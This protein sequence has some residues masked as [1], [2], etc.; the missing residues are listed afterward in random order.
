MPATAAPPSLRHRP[1]RRARRARRPLAGR[2]LPV[3]LLL[4]LFLGPALAGVPAPAPAEAQAPQATPTPV[5][6][7]R[8]DPAGPPARYAL[9]RSDQLFVLKTQQWQEGQG[10]DARSSTY[11]FRSDLSGLTGYPTY[12]ET[13]LTVTDPPWPA[14]PL[15]GRFTDPLHEQAQLLNQGTDCPGTGPGGCSYT[16]VLAEPQSGDGAILPW[17]TTVSGPAGG[18]PAAAAAGDLDGR[19]SAQGFPNDEAVVAYPGVGGALQVS[20]LDYNVTPGQTAE[21]TPVVTLPALGT[22]AT[23]P[24]SLGVGVGDLDNDGQNEVAVLWQG[25]GCAAAGPQCLSVPHLSILRYTND[26][27]SQSLAVLQADVPLPAALLTGSPARNMGF[28]VAV[29]DFDGQ[30]MD[31]LAFS[32]IGP[33]AGLAVLGFAP[34]DET[35]T[36]ARFGRDPGDFTGHSYCPVGGCDPVAAQAVPQLAAG[37]F[38]YDE[39][40]GHGLGRRQLA[41]V[42]LSNSIPGSGVQVAV[43]VYDVG[44]AG[45]TCVPAAGSP[46]LLQVQG[47]LTDASGAGGVPNRQLAW[48]HGNEGALFAP[49]I[50]LA[51]GGFQGLVLHPSDPSKVP[52]ALAVGLSG[53]S[54]TSGQIGSWV[55]L[56]GFSGS[57]QGQFR[58]DL[59][60]QTDID[61]IAT[62]PRLLAYDPPG[63]S[64]V[65]GAP[66][67]FSFADRYAPSYI[68]QDP[69]KHLDWFYDPQQKHGSWL[70]VDRSD[71][72]NLDVSQ[73]K[74]S[75][76]ESQT[77]T[78]SDWTIG[79]SV[80]VNVTAS[81]EVGLDKVDDAKAGVDASTEVG[82]QYDKNQSSYDTD[83]SSRTLTLKVATNDDDFLAGTAR[84][85]HVY[86]YPILGRPL[87]DT[88]GR[89][90]LGP[91]GQPQ[92]GFY[93]VTLPGGTVPF[94]P[95][96]GRNF[97]DWYQPLHSNGN[98]LSYPPIDS[99]P[100]SPT[101]GLVKLDPSALGPAVTLAGGGG[102]LP[103]P[104]LNQAYMVD[105]TGSSV[106]LEISGTTGHGNS[107]S[108]NNTL[109]ES[110]DV[111][112]GLSGKASF[113]VGEVSG[114]ADVD[115]KLNNS[116][117]WSA[118]STSSTTTTS[119]NAFTLNQSGAAQGDWAYGAATAY[120]TDPAGVYRAAHAVNLLA[121]SEATSEWKQYYGGRPDP[122]LNLPNRMVM[123]YSQVD[124][125][126]DIP[127]WN[128]SDSRQQ[129]R[130]FFALHPDAAHGG[131]AGPLT[132]GAPFPN[133]TDGDT[134]QLQVRVHN[135][136]LNIAATNVPVEFW[137]VARDAYDENNER[138]PVKLGTV[139]IP[140][141]PALGW[142]PAN[143]LWDTKGMAPTGAQLYR[144]FVIVAAND[145]SKGAADP[146]NNV[147]HAWADRYGDPATV[148]GTRSGDR[149]TDP[150]TG[151]YETL[152]AG[153]NKQGYGE[154][155]IYPNP[156]PNPAPAALTAAAGAPAGAPAKPATPLRFGSGGLRVTS[157]GTRA[158]APAAAAGAGA[159]AAAPAPAPAGPTTDRPQ[160]VRLHLGATGTALGNSFCHDD[161]NSATLMLYEGAPEQGGQLV[162]VER[163]TGLAGSGPAGRWVT[164]PWTPRGTGRTQLVA[165]LYGAAP[166]AR[167]APA[168]ATL[169]VD[170]A[171]PAAPPATLGRLLEVLEV[172]WLP[173][174]LR[175]ALAA[176]VR[177]A[178][179]AAL[180][181]DQP[182]ARAAL[183]A[184]RQQVEAARGRTVSGYTVSRL[185]P[186]VDDLLAQ[187]AIAG[188]CLPGSAVP[189]GAAGT[190]AGASPAAGPPGPA[191]ATASPSATATPA[192]TPAPA[193]AAGAGGA[194]PSAGTLPPC[195]PG[196][197]TAS[198]TPTPTAAATGTPP[199][200]TASPTPTA[201]PAGP[202]PTATPTP[203]PGASGTLGTPAPAG[204]TGTPART[205][206]AGGSPTPT[207]TPTAPAATPTA[208]LTPP[209]ATPATATPVPPTAT[210]AAAT[211]TA[212]PPRA[213][214]GQHLGAQPAHVQAA[215]LAT[216][217]PAAPAQWV[218][219]HEAELARPAP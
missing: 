106:T 176:R 100:Q 113:G 75:A 210:P 58:T 77:T 49:T 1:A 73:N 124:K 193:G 35:F 160:E 219:E 109:S 13:G 74:T 112:A 126:N 24:G 104:L 127:T 25:P 123:T 92:Y 85:W 48:L 57:Q 47:L 185:N 33:D 96:G 121:S 217:G 5:G 52:W 18:S 39:A 110:A 46:C 8:S 97:G 120:Y 71:S 94:G 182:G 79:G 40:S 84:S 218:A 116:N 154:V 215:F 3:A 186:L 134:V 198:P 34:L 99:D 62:S 188:L 161:N 202:S 167:T 169:A 140:A 203:T 147:V 61:Q 90:V 60:L 55:T 159:L 81:G 201:T 197:A 101:R 135:Y 151:Q 208:T 38:W 16:I 91:G 70:Q 27:T 32:F 105:P 162:G 54:A 31:E 23:G 82:D 142:Q 76:Y 191:T 177:A 131:T 179:A 78:G 93:E 65:L 195:L 153:Q 211:A 171:P 86:R 83:S 146:W 10:P 139:T 11:A 87:Q 44:A 12:A 42:A 80:T 165:R 216:H 63:A 204:G 119:T 122:A 41:L 66:V 156:S 114:C 67:V 168:E 206:P 130:G 69:P 22:A 163:V 144:I 187:P 137:A 205:P 19:V 207:A 180:A 56:Y 141:I 196:T 166:A 149:L 199:T 4:A 102:T 26:G 2:A 189:A 175:A 214:D 53:Q 37:L 128:N 14:V 68:L 172:V 59:L 15:R 64:L 95:G 174:D 157:P 17:I 164:L 200:A 190:N 158:A 170:V 28:Q 133:P 192:R 178:G 212:A 36:V 107:S 150:F 194:A 183:T 20:V 143:F 50:S 173:A 21:T 209:P 51:A 43:Q 132:A 138:S 29:G 103:Q 145:P 155:T 125:A 98:A 129:I 72:L 45:P 184:L 115:L 152:E 6:P 117:S 108:T 118:L 181:G 88:Q 89:P 148:D 111:D 30:G 136:S 7:P 213:A 9:A